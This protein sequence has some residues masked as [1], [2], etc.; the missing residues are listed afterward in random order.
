MYISL[1][2]RVIINVSNL[3]LYSQPFFFLYSLHSCFFYQFG[4]SFCSFCWRNSSP[5][6]S[7]R[8]SYCWSQES[9]R[10]TVK[11]DPC[12]SKAVHICALNSVSMCIN[13]LLLFIYHN[14][15]CVRVL[16]L[17]YAC[18]DVDEC[19]AI[20]GICQGGNCINTVGSFECKCPAGHKFNE[21]SQK[22]EGKQQWS[23]ELSG[24]RCQL[25]WQSRL[26]DIF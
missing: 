4:C 13:F 22:C 14:N 3:M 11:T 20:P 21:I 18:T 8:L 26:S 7:F 16:I 17:W 9:Q 2:V 12:T 10:E 1:H 24:F 23:H 5:P 19:Q 15:V 25:E 6:V